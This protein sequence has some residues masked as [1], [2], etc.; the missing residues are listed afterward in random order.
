MRVQ[1]IT[2]PISDLGHEKVPFC[3]LKFLESRR[4]KFHEDST[5]STH[6]RHVYASRDFV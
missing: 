6:G 1:K 4:G 5:S 3:M 2:P